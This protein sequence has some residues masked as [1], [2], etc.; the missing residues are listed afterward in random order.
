ML[1]EDKFETGSEPSAKWSCEN[2][3]KVLMEVKNE[4][5]NMEIKSLDG[6][7]SYIVETQKN[8]IGEF[9]KVLSLAHMCVAE[10]FTNKNG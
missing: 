3:N 8:L 5:I 2:Y 6:S 10:A 1:E 4:T 7:D 9:F